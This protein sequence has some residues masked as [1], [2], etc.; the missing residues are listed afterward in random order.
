MRLFIAVDLTAEQKQALEAL[1]LLIKSYL[2]GMR[3]VRPEGFHLTLFFF[4]ETGSDK[5]AQIN[6]AMH[7]A[8]SSMP[9]FKLSLAGSGV[10]PSPLNAKVIW[11]GVDEGEKEL[12]SLKSA[13]DLHLT[14]TGFEPDKRLFSPHLTLAR[15]RFPLAGNYI[16]RFL[17]E[18]NNFK[19][20]SSLVTDLTLYE[21]RLTQQ[22]ALY[23][24][25]TK[26][27][28]PLVRN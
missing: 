18:E 2:P 21:S 6:L 8:A 12:K 22:G 24:P 13:L 3:W 25:Q 19:T 11:M 9:P 16:N 14:E 23:Y 1:Q 26:I 17:K 20:D 28:L 4:G 10:F 5:I 7:K 27:K 15:T